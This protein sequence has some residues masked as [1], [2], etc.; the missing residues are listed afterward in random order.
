MALPVDNR[1]IGNFIT[2]TADKVLGYITDN[3][4]NTNAVW[5]KLYQRYND[6][7]DTIDDSGAEIR[8]PIIYAGVKAGSY[9]QGF[10]FPTAPS[11]F[12]TDMQFQYRRTYAAINFDGGEIA[13]N[14]AAGINRLFNLVEVTIKNAWMTLTDLMGYQIFST[15]LDPVT[16]VT[17]AAIPGPNDWDGLYN[18]VD[19]VGGTYGTYG[20]I[21]RVATPGT[22][23][24][25]INANVIN[26]QA[27]P[28]SKS[29]IQLACGRATFNNEKPDLIA[30][31]QAQWN[32]LWDRVEPADRNPPGPLRDV[33]FD[34]MRFSGGGAEIVAD[35]H[36]LP[37]E[38]WVLNTRM[39]KLFLMPGRDF[40]RRATAEGFS[41]KG[42]PVPNQDANIDQLIA[43]G[44]LTVPG[45][46][47]QSK[48][49]NLKAAA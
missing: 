16:G 11:E 7:E 41:E 45:P 37:T 36:V 44:N 5:Q 24:G 21:T 32:A 4:F 13:I 40:V 27:N 3:F 47:F 42:F 49:T 35:S 34:T 25:A 29:I 15:Q 28:I 23:G 20:G 8:V 33:G 9:G 17:I 26:A 31:E 46:R 12:L 39:L 48:I 43:M 14:A 38:V 30:L 2:T 10:T 1:A 22:P 6:G 19:T 18:G